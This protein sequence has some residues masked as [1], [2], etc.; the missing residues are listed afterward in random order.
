MSGTSPA[1]HRSCP[2]L[3][4][5]LSPSEKIHRAQT[6]G[7]QRPALPRPLQTWG[8]VS[9]PRLEAS[10]RGEGKK[11]RA[12]GFMTVLMLSQGSLAVRRTVC[13]TTG[14]RPC[15]AGL[16]VFLALGAGRQGYVSR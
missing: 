15:W 3:H 7:G 5:W 16:C 10:G 4:P 11:P 12:E 9:E 1:A 13:A 8:R 6:P 14:P 2:L